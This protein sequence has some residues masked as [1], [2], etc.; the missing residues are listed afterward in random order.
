MLFARKGAVAYFVD[1]RVDRLG[2]DST[3][4]SIAFDEFRGETFGQPENVMND[5]DLPIAKRTGA[6]ANGRNRQLFSD[7]AGQVQRHPFHDHGKRASFSNSVRVI[8]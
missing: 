8:D 7:L 5:Q 2:N 6:D 1:V 3:Q 4:V